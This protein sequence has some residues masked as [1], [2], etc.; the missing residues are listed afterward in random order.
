M[1]KFNQL[2]QFQKEMQRYNI[3]LNCLRIES[4]DVNFGTHEK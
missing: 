3:L 1:E 2:S 4:T